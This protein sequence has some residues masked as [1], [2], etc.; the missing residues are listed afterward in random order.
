M[1]RVNIKD[2]SGINGRDHT[3]YT[4]KTSG[5]YSLYVQYL[6]GGSHIANRVN[7][8]DRYLEALKRVASLSAGTESQPI[9]V[10]EIRETVGDIDAIDL[11]GTIKKIIKQTKPFFIARKIWGIDII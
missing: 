6:G 8:K 4:S 7:N 9:S 3:E 10:Y 2:V 11:S 1:S 5:K